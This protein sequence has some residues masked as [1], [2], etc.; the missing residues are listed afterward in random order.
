MLASSFLQPGDPPAVELCNE[1]GR[2]RCLFICDHASA[3]IPAV[4]GDLGLDSA[5]RRQHIAWDIGAAD[6][7]RRLA[8]RLD[9]PAI[10]SGYSR[11]V[12]D[13]NRDLED[14]TSIAQE[15][16]E[17][18]V[19]GNRKLS[20]EARRQRAGACF[21]PYHHAIGAQIRRMREAGR[22][23]ALISLHSFTP[24]MQG[25]ERPWHI[26]V[27]WNRDDRLAGPL[28]AALARDSTICAGDNQPYDGRGGRGYGTRV[29]GEQGGLPHALLEVRQD[30]ID[31]HHG[32]EAWAGRLASILDGIFAR[33]ALFEGMS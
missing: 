4:L 30:L 7:T 19:P 13:C 24:V 14:P 20:T 2:A 32:A 15:S 8:V 28:L 12:I 25:F 27:L 1:A 11:L 16:D 6:L 21:W 9:A 23:P 33:A 10:L 17:V 5:Q 26:G 18:A 29:H 3:A 31:T 22:A